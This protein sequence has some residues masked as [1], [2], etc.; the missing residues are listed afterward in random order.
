MS[1]IASNSLSK[2]LSCSALI[3]LILF[4]AKEVVAEEEEEL[5]MFMVSL[6]TIPYPPDPM[7]SLLLNLIVFFNKTFDFR[8][9]VF[10]D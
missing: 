1:D 7:I 10:G 4:T 3:L 2:P 8:V 5:F 9:F 6:Y